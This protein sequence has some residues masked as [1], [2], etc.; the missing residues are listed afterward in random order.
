M[1]SYSSCRRNEN[2]AAIR[3]A[4]ISARTQQIVTGR[5][6]DTVAAGPPG[7]PAEFAASPRLSESKPAGRY[8][9][10]GP[11]A[12]AMPSTMRPANPTP[13]A[14]SDERARTEPRKVIDA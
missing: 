10:I 14:G 9:V 7:E 4:A 13:A 5:S 2:Q 12:E 3:Q 1:P 11:I 6:A 8:R